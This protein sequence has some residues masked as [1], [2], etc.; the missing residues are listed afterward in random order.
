MGGRVRSRTV[1]K[2]GGASWSVAGV[3]TVGALLAG[4][5]SDVTR[6]DYPAFGLTTDNPQRAARMAPPEN[7]QDGQAPAYAGA[8][9]PDY[10][11][12]APVAP[13]YVYR[14]PV[15]SGGY[16][17]QGYGTPPYGGAPK[18]YGSNYDQGA[19]DGFGTVQGQPESYKPGRFAPNGP[20]VYAPPPAY[21]QAAP[22][23]GDASGFDVGV[24]AA[25][26]A[27]YGAPARRI[28]APIVG[29]QPPYT[30]RRPK[31]GT[32][33][34]V[35]PGETLYQVA[36]RNGVSVAALMQL[37]RLR[38]P[39]VQPGQQLAMPGKGGRSI[40]PPTRPDA[41]N[42]GFDQGPQLASN[43]PSPN[44]GAP[45]LT[46]T[47][48]RIA[49]PA[50]SAF[51]NPAA[52]D[53]SHDNP[54]GT[55]TVRAGDSIYS[56]ARKHGLQPDAI[57]SANGLVDITKVKFGQTLR[58]PGARPQANNA[59]GAAQGAIPAAGTRVAAL[60]H[61]KPA[62][63][64]MAPAGEQA[65]VMNDADM[66]AMPD[67]ADASANDPSLTDGGAV[68]GA[69][70]PTFK[71]TTPAKSGTVDPA[72]RKVV[73]SNDTAAEV[74]SD[75]RFRW[76]V[77]GRI[78][79]KFGPTGKAGAANE[80]IDM[81]VPQGTEVHAAENGVVAYSGDEL[82]GYGKLVLI[83]HADNWVTAYAHNDEILVKR[84]DSIRRGQVIAKSGKSGGVDQPL[85]HFELR[86]GSQPI[87]PMPHMAS[88]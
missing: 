80:G 81:A 3:L 51:A 86:K 8:P 85:L 41:A 56:I 30:G 53:R 60:Q 22:I 27:P 19:P 50:A 12:G 13:K 6:F 11:A 33:V 10:N 77:R 59:T 67:T 65:P 52:I 66:D 47:A 4:C 31:A 40:L 71:P 61:G 55:Y 39:V 37:N 64:A 17:A 82:K 38:S 43:D 70:K 14:G 44:N 84:G 45:K 26:A 73:A 79:G 32:L 69:A 49:P 46:G 23:G 78:V 74:P 57:M 16:N 58:L 62:M 21:G 2:I 29:V 7:I 20:T 72:S 68:A 9:P 83:R 75:G 34:T 48:L 5:S 87:D 42:T 88:N 1:S 36:K 24:P 28:M 63:P 76:P 15:Q 54:D 25:E 35:L 18:V